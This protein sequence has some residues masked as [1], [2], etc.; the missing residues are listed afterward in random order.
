MPREHPDAVKF[1][2]DELESRLLLERQSCRSFATCAGFGKRFA[3]RE[4]DL[5]TTSCQ[6][7]SKNGKVAHV[8]PH[9][10]GT[11][12]QS[13]KV[14]D[15]FGISP[16]STRRWTLLSVYEATLM[17]CSNGIRK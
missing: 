6:R 13:V 8:Q 12:L 16:G 9:A 14:M 4:S 3:D 17:Q 2:F 11:A 10:D 1:Y 5:R 7:S 15:Y